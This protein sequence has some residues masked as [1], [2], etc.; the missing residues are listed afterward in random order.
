MIPTCTVSPLAT[1]ATKWRLRFWPKPRDGASCW[2]LRW[3]LWKGACWSCQS[4]YGR[5]KWGKIGGLCGVCGVFFNFY[6]IYTVFFCFLLHVQGVYSF[7]V[8]SFS[9]VWGVFFVFKCKREMSLSFF[10]ESGAFFFFFFSVMNGL[11]YEWKCRGLGQEAEIERN[12]FLRFFLRDVGKDYSNKGQ[13][14]QR[15]QQ[16]QQQ[17]NTAHIEHHFFP[18]QKNFRC[19]FHKTLSRPPLFDVHSTGDML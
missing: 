9:G 10:G 17:Q 3:K 5:K 4:L 19:S 15:Q 6:Y 13:R 18:S 7:F 11:L 2:T 1:K 8:F 16:Q 12:V 14:R